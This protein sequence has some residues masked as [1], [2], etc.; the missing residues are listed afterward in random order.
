MAVSA[1]SFKGFEKFYTGLRMWWQMSVRVVILL[2]IIQLIFIGIY[3]KLN[4]LKMGGIESKQGW[5]IVKG[6]H[7]NLLPINVSGSI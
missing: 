1:N 5:C 7:L 2:I 3:T 4:F 6:Y